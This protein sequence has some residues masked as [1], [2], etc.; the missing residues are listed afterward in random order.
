MKVILFV[1][2]ATCDAAKKPRLFSNLSSYEF[3]LRNVGG[4]PF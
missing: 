3:N 2:K 1:C 4:T